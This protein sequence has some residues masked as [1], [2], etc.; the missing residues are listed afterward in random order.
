MKGIDERGG[1][2]IIPFRELEAVVSKVSLEEF[3]SKEIQKRA[4]EEINWIIEKSVI[5]EKVVE[6][7]M[8]RNDKILSVIPMKFGTVFKN[9]EGLEKS[10]NKYYKKFKTTLEKLEGKQEWGI[11]LYLVDRKKF[12]QG[13]KSKSQ[14]IKEKEKEIA[15]LP[16]GAAYFLEG[17]LSE[18]ISRDIDKKLKEMQKALFEGFKNYSEQSVEGKILEKELTGR[19]EP[20][21]LNASYLIKKEKVEDFRNEAERVNQKIIPKGFILEISGPW[22]PYNFI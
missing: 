9:R 15:D 18:L 19:L 13:V 4:Q 14:I 21:I 3:E 2:F 1:V 17:K 7:A 16:E 12:E 6:E 20:V 8:R 11:K 10:L 5:H 22:P